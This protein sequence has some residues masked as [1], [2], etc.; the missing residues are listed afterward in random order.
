M[1]RVIPHADLEAATPAIWRE[2]YEVNVIAPWE[3]VRAAA[4]IL[5]K[6]PGSPCVV[7]M[8]SHAGVRP[9]G[10]S[11]PY[12]VSKAGLVHMT[13]LL[14]VALAPAIRVNAIAPG[15]VDT[16]LTADWVEAQRLWR[17]RSPMRRAAVPEDLAEIAMM[18]INSTYLTGEV[19]L[20]D[21][22]LSLT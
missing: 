9:K 21:G 10:S 16:P 6:S 20:A 17:E 22:G 7:N 4:P 12:A 19:I 11:I 8:A 13:K 14:A 18:L 3:L 1:S 5:R 15:L 2:L